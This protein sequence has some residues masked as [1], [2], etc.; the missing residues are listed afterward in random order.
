MDCPCDLCGSPA[1]L[2]ELEG[3][4]DREPSILDEAQR[5]VDGPRRSTYGTPADNHGRTAVLWSA[6]LHARGRPAALSAED[7][8]W[9]NVLQKLAR[10]LHGPNRDSLVDV[11]GYVLNVD[12]LRRG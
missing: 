3:R 11:V 7:V 6:Y 2:A 4:P 1:G 10:E 5:I 12:E 9:L 8:C